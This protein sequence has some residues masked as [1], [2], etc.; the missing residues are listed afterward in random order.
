MFV[1]NKVKLGAG[2]C[3]GANRW[4]KCDKRCILVRKGPCDPVR[5]VIIRYFRGFFQC[6]Q[7]KAPNGSCF[8]EPRFGA[9]RPGPQWTRGPGRSGRDDQKLG[10]SKST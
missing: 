10:L 8:F 3:Y 7:R 4:S 1:A 9:S 6:G 2:R 5:G